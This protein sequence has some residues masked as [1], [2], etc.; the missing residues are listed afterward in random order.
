MNGSEAIGFQP[1]DGL[2]AVELGHHDV[3]QYQ[4][5]QQLAGLF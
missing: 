2:D 3:E 1:L 5:R 4:V